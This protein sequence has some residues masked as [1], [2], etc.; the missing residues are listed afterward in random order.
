VLDL[1]PGLDEQL[2]QELLDGLGVDPGGSE[3]GVDLG[4]GQVGG[5]DFA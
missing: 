5:Q 3:P 2:A 1:D 4:R